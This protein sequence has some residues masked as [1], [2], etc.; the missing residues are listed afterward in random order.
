MNGNFE[1]DEAMEYEDYLSEIDE[2]NSI[3]DEQVVFVNRDDIV[4]DEELEEIIQT[5]KNNKISD[6]ELVSDI[7]NFSIFLYDKEIICDNIR[8]YESVIGTGYIELVKDD[9]VIDTF[10]ICNYNLRFITILEN[11]AY[12]NL[13]LKGV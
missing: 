9:V 5:E 4:S 13:F 6:D 7:H 1:F 12:Y 10:M 11:I 8:Y 3:A 2:I